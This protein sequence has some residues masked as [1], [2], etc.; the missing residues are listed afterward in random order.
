MRRLGLVLISLALLTLMGMGVLWQVSRTDF[1]WRWGG[2]RLVALAQ[3]R[4]QG[5]LKVQDIKGN[6]L[7][8]LSFEG[9]TLQEPRGEVLQAERLELRFSLWSLV[10]LQP[11]VAY[12]GLYRPRLRLSRDEQGRWNAGR[13]LKPG[14]AAAPPFTALDFSRIVVKRGEIA[15]T[16]AGESRTFSEIDFQGAASVRQP[17][18]PRQTISVPG[19]DLSFSL[20][21]GRYRLN[22]SLTHTREALDIPSLIVYS[23]VR[24]LGAL[25]GQIKLNDAEPLLNL[26]LELE[27]GAGGELHRVWP[28]WPEAWGLAG[29]FQISG[30]PSQ[31]QV[32]GDGALQKAGYSLKGRLGRQNGT[33]RYDLALQ[34]RGLRSQ[35][36]TD[37]QPLWAEKIKNLEALDVLAQLKGEGF[38]WPPP[39]LKWSLECGPFAYQDAQ[40]KELKL[41]LEGDPRLQR[42]TCQAQGDFGRMELQASGALLTAAAGDLKVQ[43]EALQPHILGVSPLAQ[44]TITGKYSGAFSLAP[45]S[46]AGELEA[47]GQLGRQPLKELKGRLH[48]D[49]AKL[50]IPQ[51]KVGLGSLAADFKGF[52][53]KKGLEVQYRGHAAA[54]GAWPWA[55]PDWRGRL[56][57]EGAIKGPWSGPQIT[58]QGKGQG[59]SGGGF[60]AE[61]LGI[62]VEAAGWLPQAGR[63]ELHGSGLKTP[64]MQFSQGRFTCQGEAG[65]WRF[66]FQGSSTQGSADLEGQ[67]DLK[68]RPYA[69]RLDR[70]RLQY[71]TFTAT[72]SGPVQL[73]LDQGWELAPASFR[74]N[75]GQL[76]LQA[77]ART[78]RLT[79]RAEF[80]SM[81]A[82]ILCLVG[83][84]CQ[85]KMEGHLNLSG[86]PVHPVIQGR[87]TWGPGQWGNFSFKSM[88]SA[89]NYRDARLYLSG[90]LEESSAGPGLAWEGHIPLTLTLLPLKWALGDR[91]LNF[92]VQGEN[93]NLAMLTALTP[94]IPRA[95]GPLGV[96]AVWQGNP[97]QPT[98]SGHLRWGEG[99]ITFRQAGTPY[100]I[101]PGQ[102]RLQG[103]RLIVP[104]LTLMSG[105]GAA[106][107]SGEVTLPKVEA[108]AALQ[109][110][111][112]VKRTGSEVTGTGN[113]TLSGP[114]S[115]P[116]LKGRLTIPRASFIPGFF[117]SMDKHDD[118][119]LVARQEPPP[120]PANG[121]PQIPKLTF[122]KNLRMDLDLETSGNVWLKDKRLNVEMAGKITALKESGQSARVRGE[123]RA[124]R[125]T[126][127]LQ[128]RIFKVEQGIVRLPGRPGEDVTV[129]AKATHE[130]ANLTMIL[131]ATGAV[132][133]PQVRL[134]SVPPLPPQDLLAYLLFGR[135]ARSLTREEN[136]SAGQQAAG[137]FGGITAKK[138]QELLG[139]DF[140]LVG[141][142]TV[143]TPQSETGR[144]AVGVTK[145]LTKDL[146]VGF[147]RKFDPLH[148]DQSEQAILEYRVNKYLS[149][150]SQMGRRNTGAD[151]LFNLDF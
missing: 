79:G 36:L 42:L 113:L 140:P 4:L 37:L 124:L 47:R 68:A 1:F 129:E 5:E 141:D 116:L 22:A 95:D 44:S 45:W 112:A 67:A 46:T 76:S 131:T 146:S 150:E 123:I 16:L 11:A 2:K 92:R 26:A 94:E 61:S 134:E 147:E 80:S 77:V 40:V 91:D 54:D 97:R 51:A 111:I 100:R 137:I 33:W 57:G 82:D 43:T 56:E 69:L 115:S 19:A 49:G 98:V 151:V 102:A 145:P 32:T 70:C 119:I 120:P 132:G 144:Q 38:A 52:I 139:K 103:D 136:L 108:K 149:V 106:R 17:G 24:P 107:L 8:G 3:E 122:Y 88:S 143:R 75:D 12:V 58:F 74:V 10:K 48:W 63:L 105:G 117:R 126:Y 110:F 73:R 28:K 59:L 50:H 14:P 62:R 86:D 60:A 90:R 27:I 148:R 15:L 72:N 93:A 135:P 83:A 30:P 23:Q 29:K 64:V 125:G 121:G 99:S 34:L 81:P 55:P 41:A 138:I 31:F 18:R 142:V 53:E 114:W 65:R 118:V 85:G 101:L 71:Q 20:P 84:S 130:I 89:I 104:E 66:G 39:R 78:G 127:D 35:M 13:L 128:G 133:K 9:I 25:A 96:E 21:Q 7:T 6:P 109:N 87:L